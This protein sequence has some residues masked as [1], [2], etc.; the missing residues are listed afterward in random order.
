[1]EYHKKCW[2]ADYTREILLNSISSSPWYQTKGKKKNA[3][4]LPSTGLLDPERITDPEKLHYA[5]RTSTIITV[6]TPWIMLFIFC[7]GKF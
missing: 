1:M 3:G 4:H 2:Q 7:M 5:L 6:S